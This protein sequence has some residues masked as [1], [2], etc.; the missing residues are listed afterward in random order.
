MLSRNAGTSQRY[1]FH[2][3]DFPTAEP[4]SGLTRQWQ[5]YIERQVA[6]SE[7]RLLKLCMTATGEVLAEERK[8][9]RAEFEA[10]LVKVRAEIEQERA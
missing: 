6:R 1:E 2:I 9:L 7:Q 3:D 4:P 5:A 8:K 10:E